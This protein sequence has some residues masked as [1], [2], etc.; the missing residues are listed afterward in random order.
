[1]KQWAVFHSDTILDA[2]KSN[3]AARKERAN[4]RFISDEGTGSR[5]AAS[6]FREESM[7]DR[8]ISNSGKLPE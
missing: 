7:L 3:V 2:A 8:M 5:T 4:R 6:H 1:M